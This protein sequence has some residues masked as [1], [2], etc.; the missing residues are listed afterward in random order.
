MFEKHEYPLF[1]EFEFKT[2]FSTDRCEKNDGKRGLVEEEQKGWILQIMWIMRQSESGP[3]IF[4]T[5]SS[6]I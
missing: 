4:I 2:P 3:C 5:G 1:W 6:N